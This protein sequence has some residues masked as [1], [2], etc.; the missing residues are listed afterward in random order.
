MG[1][2]EAD[3]RSFLIGW[4]E[5]CMATGMDRQSPGQTGL[6]MRQSSSINDLVLKMSRAN[7]VF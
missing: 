6:V 2:A 4:F 3:L 1:M 7:Q 5:V